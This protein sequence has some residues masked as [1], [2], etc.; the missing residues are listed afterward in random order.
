MLTGSLPSLAR[1]WFHFS[2]VGE[3]GDRGA[4][5][6]IRVVVVRNR[7][8]EGRHDRVAD[9]LV[10]HALFLLQ[11]VDHQREILVEQRHRPLRTE[12][13]GQ[14]GEAADV[15]KQ[16]RRLDVLPAQKIGARGEEA[17]RDARV[18]IARHGRLEA[19]LR[20]D[21]LEDDHRADALLVDV[22]QRL[23]GKVHRQ[24][25]LA[26]LERRIDADLLLAGFGHQL[27]LVEHPGVLFAEEVGHRRMHD[28][29]R[30]RLQ[31]AQARGVAGRHPLL[32][33]QRD[34]A[35]RHRLEHRFVVVLHRLHVGEE[36]R[37]L[38]RDRHLR[39]KGAQARLV[40]VRKRAAVLVQH[41]R[42]A[43]RLALLV[44]H[45]HAEDRARE[46]VGLLVERRVEAQVGVGVGDVDGLARLEHRAGDAQVVRQ[47]DLQRLEPLADF[48]P[49]LAWSSRR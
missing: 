9:E 4:H 33:V 40:L 37:V 43:D 7:D 28:V 48:G 34:E 18:H 2:S 15:G 3:H 16:H 23:H 24:G 14:R 1:C 44:D 32:R 25:R 10:E 20:T 13:L 26:H 46:V 12:L 21:V 11:A 45:R 31:D 36:L 38:E 6:A 19:L 47:A 39:G 41:L 17:I 42:H 29:L 30:G 8:P 22:E 5:R 49:E 27:E 35:V